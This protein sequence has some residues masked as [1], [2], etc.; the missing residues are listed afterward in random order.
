[1]RRAEAIVATFLSTVVVAIAVPFVW[2]GINIAIGEFSDVWAL[3]LALCTAAYGASLIGSVIWAWFG[4]GTSAVRFIKVASSA[5]FV[6]YAAASMDV[7]MI[8]GLEFAVIL[9]IGVLLWVGWF[10]VRYVA[11]RRVT[12]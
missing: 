8:S 10:S 7:G 3:F 5:F 1:M 9:F 4:G 6:L 11:Q 2:Y 12:A